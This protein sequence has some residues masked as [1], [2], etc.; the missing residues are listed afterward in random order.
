MISHDMEVAADFASRALV[1]SKG[2]LTGDGTVREI[3]KNRAVL[4][5]ASLLPAQIPA[6]AMTLGGA[7]ADAFT[8]GDMAGIAEKLCETRGGAAS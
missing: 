2:R 4:D 1:L 7:F 8:I 6:L 5:G 3:M